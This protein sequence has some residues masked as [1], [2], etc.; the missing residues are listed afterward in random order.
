MKIAHVVEKF[1]HLSETFALNQMAGAIERG[2]DVEIL[3]LQGPTEHLDNV[4][5]I[6]DNYNLLEKVKFS[7][8]IPDNFLVRLAKLAGHLGRSPNRNWP[9]VL[10]LLNGFRY[11][12]EAFALRLLYRAMPLLGGARYDIIHCQFGTTGLVA[13]LFRDLGL[14]DGQLVV[15]FRGRDISWAVNHYGDRVY[16]R[17][18]REA[19]V[20]LPNSRFFGQ[21]VLDLGGDPEKLHVHGSG[22]D[23]ARFQFKPRSRQSEGTTRIVTIGRLVEKKG[24]EYAIRA[25][26]KLA[27]THPAIDYAIIGDGP[28]K[29]ELQTLI[30]RLNVGHIVTLLGWKRQEELIDILDCSHILVAPS[31]TA[32]DGDADA[33]VNTLK[34]AMAMGLP[35]IGTWHG[36][37]PELLE[38]GRSGYLV[39]ERD[40]DALA[41]RL[42]DLIDRPQDWATMGAIG[43]KKVETCY[44]MNVLNDDLIAIYASLLKPQTS[45][46]TTPIAV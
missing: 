9:V 18:F 12:Q 22:I 28:L 7:P 25:V 33:P 8:S 39:P 29:Q 23:T 44:D 2:H 30:D 15:S 42:A 45:L 37:I 3:A 1:P 43:R 14:L 35:A 34:E 4:H 27:P 36:G 26:A 41:A 38:D 16:D 13:L 20:Y 21:R 40:V 6:V 19:S 17:L 5:P 46:D 11:G 10:Q 32:D 24:I 31:V